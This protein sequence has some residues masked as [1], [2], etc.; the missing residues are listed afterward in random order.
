MGPT[1]DNQGSNLKAAKSRTAT[2]KSLAAA[3]LDGVGA[4]LFAAKYTGEVLLRIEEQGVW[5]RWTHP[6]WN[7]GGPKSI[8]RKEASIFD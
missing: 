8:T 6:A 4:L 7:L 2:L 1:N 3:G 5:S